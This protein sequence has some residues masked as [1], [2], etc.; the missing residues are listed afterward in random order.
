M[1]NDEM[2]SNNSIVSVVH[3]WA[4]FQ[5]PM[6]CHHG[7]VIIAIHICLEIWSQNC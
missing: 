5:L 4:R 7:D 2:I 3:T 6:G 1:C